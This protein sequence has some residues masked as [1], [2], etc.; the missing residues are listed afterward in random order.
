VRLAL[1][2]ADHHQRFAEVGLRIT[3]RVRERHE[4][5]TLA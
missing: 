3:R 1:D 4:H 5:L 2:S